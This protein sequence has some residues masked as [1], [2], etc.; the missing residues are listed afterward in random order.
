MKWN[1]YLLLILIAFPVL[2]FSQDSFKGGSKEKF[3]ESKQK[4]S[5]GLDAAEKEKLEVALRVLALAAIYDKDHQPALKKQSFDELVWKR[6]NGKTLAETYEL[7]NQYIKADH[8][9]KI[10]KLE[11]EMSVLEVKKRKSDA[12]KAKLSVLKA[13][14]LRVDSINGQFVIFCAFTNESDQVLN[15]Y[16]TVIGYGSTEDL[17][18][19]WSCIK[20]PVDSAVFA[21]K[22]TKVLSCSFSFAS[23][24]ENSNVI[25][26]KE[27]KYPLTDFSAYKLAMDCYTSMLVL[28]GVK[29]ELKNEERLSQQE[30]QDLSKY[31]ANLDGL[32][33]NIPVLEDL[34][35]KKP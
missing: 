28:N 29:Y 11:K 16:E 7:A 25:K 1:R 19:G 10:E 6:L 30:E 34:I 20:A 23:V 15:T 14:P 3:E 13:K 4:I 33:A 35:V 8:Q 32:K 2:G 26:W 12:L 17:N 18:D 24:K 21:P 31:S 27:I 5:A 9:R 22:E